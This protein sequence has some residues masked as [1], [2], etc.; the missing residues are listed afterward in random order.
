[1]ADWRKVA[2]AVI[3]ADGSVS[4]REVKVLKKQLY[5][6][7]KITHEELQFL[8]DL[9]SAAMK[10]SKAQGLLPAF[11]KFFQKAVLDCFLDNSYISPEETKMLEAAVFADKKVSPSEKKLMEKLRAAAK[12]TCP[13]FDMLYQKVMGAK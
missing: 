1:M 12:Q 13:E 9:R 10:K 2:M 8:I 5:A 4:D 7:K 3:L 11:H 6:D